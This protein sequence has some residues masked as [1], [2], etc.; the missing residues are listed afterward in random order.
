MVTYD[1]IVPQSK[2]SS[3]TLRYPA[4]NPKGDVVVLCLNLIQ[5]LY[6]N[7]PSTGSRLAYHNVALDTTTVLS[8][9]CAA[10]HTLIP[11]TALAWLTSVTDRQ[12]D[13]QTEL[14]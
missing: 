14:R 1:V 10:N 9:S 7:I 5:C 11:Q 12:T 2:P 6:Q 3:G 8:V 13:R 4:V